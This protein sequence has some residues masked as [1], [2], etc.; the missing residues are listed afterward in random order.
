MCRDGAG[1]QM[2]HVSEP[3]LMQGHHGIRTASSQEHRRRL[4]LSKK[5]HHISLPAHSVPGRH[6]DTRRSGADL[7]AAPAQPALTVRAPLRANLLIA[8]AH[9]CRH[10]CSAPAW[11]ASAPAWYAVRPTSLRAACA[12][13]LRRARRL[14]E[15]RTR[16][17]APDAA[18]Q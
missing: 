1:Q 13:A 11:L 7:V 8:A 2:Q 17:P 3:Q 9:T 5:R 4:T 16:H 14:H 12:A 10:A 6:P 18:A 15:P